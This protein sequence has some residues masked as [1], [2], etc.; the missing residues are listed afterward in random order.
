MPHPE[1]PFYRYDVSVDIPATEVA[2]LI[3]ALDGERLALKDRIGWDELK[4][5][6][7]QE[8]RIDVHETSGVAWPELEAD[9]KTLSVYLSEPISGREVR[10]KPGPDA[11]VLQGWLI[12]GRRGETARVPL[13]LGWDQAAQAP[14]DGGVD[15]TQLGAQ[16]AALP[17]WVRASLGP[18]MRAQRT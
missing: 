9:L 17:A 8:Q 3:D 1:T 15:R 13:S 12:F 16:W 2:V 18:E 5:Q 10:V 6:L 11:P 14:V 7:E 4:R